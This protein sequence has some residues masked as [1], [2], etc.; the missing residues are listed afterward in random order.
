MSQQTE[1]VVLG[2]D[3]GLR[4]AIAVLQDGRL[5]NVIDMPVIQTASKKQINAHALIQFFHALRGAYGEVRAVVEKAQ[6]A[7]GQGAAAS[8]SYGTGFGL[9][10]GCLI[11][12]EIRYTTVTPQ[13]WRRNVGLMRGTDKKASITKAIELFPSH[14]E[15]F[16]A[17]R[18]GRA[19]AALIAL[20][21][22]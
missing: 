21:E 12:C 22:G 13:T 16:T 8:F 10:L 20:S 1:R 18:D 14:A 6:A 3:P 9:L 11:A 5:L 7:P 2:I 19:E 17:S 4:G 15:K